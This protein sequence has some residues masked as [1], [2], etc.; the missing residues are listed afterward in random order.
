MRMDGARREIEKL[1]VKLDERDFRGGAPPLVQ[2][3]LPDWDGSDLSLDGYER[4][5]GASPDEQLTPQELET[6]RRLAPYAE[7]F[8]RL[9]REKEEGE[10]VTA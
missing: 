3:G 10:D 9:G 4:A 1:R 6:R 2:D 8:Q 5:L 7:V